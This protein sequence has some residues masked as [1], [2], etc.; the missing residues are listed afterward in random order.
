TLGTQIEHR[1]NAH[2]G[3]APALCGQLMVDP[4]RPAIHCAEPGREI[5][6]GG[7]GK[8][9]ALDKMRSVIEEMGIESALLSAGASTQLAFGE[10]AW[11]IEL[12]GDNDTLKLSLQNQAL[13]ASG[14]SIQGSH[15]ISP[16]DSHTNYQFPRLWLTHSSATM[17]D[18]FS[19]AVLLMNEGESA[20]ITGSIDA[21]YFEKDGAISSL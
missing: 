3:V 2:D 19:T 14:T 13:S 12:R 1:K 4:D 18:A 21:I 11:E 20:Q 15:I 8:G 10:E 5:D 6:L 17:A 9:F 16:R 7:I